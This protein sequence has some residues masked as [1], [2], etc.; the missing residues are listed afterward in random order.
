MRRVAYKAEGKRLAVASGPLS[1][2]VLVCHADTRT[3]ECD[4]S[5]QHECTNG[6]MIRVHV[7]R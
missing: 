3:V 6:G 4:R 5:G 7:S 1:T 2:D